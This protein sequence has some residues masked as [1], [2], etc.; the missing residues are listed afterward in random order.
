MRLPNNLNTDKNGLVYISDKVDNIIHVNHKKELTH[1]YYKI[2]STNDYIIKYNLDKVDN[3]KICN[4]L[5]TFY[6]VWPNIKQIDFPIGYYGEANKPKGLIIPY[7]NDGIT[8]NDIDNINQ[9]LKY[10]NVS[11]DKYHNIY[12]LLNNIL[13]LLEEMYENEIIYTDVSLDNFSLVNGNIK[14]NDFDSKYIHFRDNY[15]NYYLKSILINYEILV[16]NLYN[17]LLN[18]KI[19][20]KSKESGFE[21]MKKYIKKIDDNL[22]K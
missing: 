6:R 17:F 14:I 21:D 18:S 15:K 3:G 20:V 4:M 2:D 7:Y 5:N 13:I 16:C 8:L 22:R 19:S 12:L 11:E 10:Y 9:L 1:K